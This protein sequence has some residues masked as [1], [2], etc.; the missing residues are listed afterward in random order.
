[1]NQLLTG[2]MEIQQSRTIQRDFYSVLGDIESVPEIVHMVRVWWKNSIVCWRIQM[3]IFS[4]LLV[5][6]AGNSPVTDEFPAQRPW[7]GAL[8]L[9]LNCAWINGWVNNR[10]ADLRRLWRKQPVGH[11][12]PSKMVI[13]RELK[14]FAFSKKKMLN[15][16]TT[17]WWFQNWWWWTSH[18]ASHSRPSPSDYITVNKSY[19]G[20]RE[21]NP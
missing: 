5:L 15:K 7:R 12:F 2:N 20:T 18:T 10:E 3:E 16:Q 9:S 14:T 1:M 17:R 4:T 8:M 21:W 13:N 11:G 19:P 6:F